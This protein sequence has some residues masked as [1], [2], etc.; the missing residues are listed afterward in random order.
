MMLCYSETGAQFVIGQVAV[1]LERN[2]IDTVL[3]AF[4]DVVNQRNFLRRTFENRLHLN[5]KIALLLKE[6]DQIALPF[7]DQIAING[8]FLVNGNQFFLSAAANK[9][10]V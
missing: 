3:R 10:K 9:G 8:P 4:V 1:A 6:V 2:V 5:V 7:V